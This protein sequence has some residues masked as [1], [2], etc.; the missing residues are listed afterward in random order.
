MKIGVAFL[1][2]II[3]TAIGTVLGNFFVIYLFHSSEISFGVMVSRFVLPAIAYVAVIS[4]L[5]GRNV[6]LF[7][8]DGFAAGNEKSFKLLKKIGAVPIKSI[9][10][11]VLVQ[12]A[13]LWIVIFILGKSLGV[14]NTVRIFLYC[15]CLA[16]GM[17]LGTLVYVI[18]DGLVMRKLLSHSITL[19]PNDLREDRQG[20]KACIIPIAVHLVS[21]VAA[22]SITVLMLDK[23]GVDVS[24]VEKGGWNIAILVLVAFCILFFIL[25]INLKKN[26]SSL[27]HSVISQLE[28]LSAGKK[29][30]RQR[31]HIASVDELGSIAG[32]MNIFCEN[33][34]ESMKEIK[35][36]QEILFASSTQLES[37]AQDMHTAV[38]RIA[39]AIVEAREKAEAGVKMLNVNQSSA[40]IHKIA[41]NIDALNG[42]VMTQSKSV[43]QASAAIEEMVGN[44]SSIGKV[45]GKMAEHFE[46]VNN[47]ADKGLSIQKNSTVSVDRI[48]AQSRALLD[49]NHIIADISS[50]TNLLAMNAAIEAAH[51][52]NAGR[53]FSVVADEIRKLAETASAESKKINEELNQ[54]SKTIDGI[55]KGT[56]SSATAFGAVSERV[57]ETENLIREVNNAIIEQQQ[58]VE[59]VLGALKRMNEITTEVKSGSGV[60]QENNNAMIGEI[61]LLQ[62]HSKDISSGMDDIT[63][64]MRNINSE[65]GEMS[66]LAADTHI[67]VEKIKNIVDSFEV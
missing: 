63:A 24:V 36:D 9:A 3:G 10:Q 33:I 6:R 27:Y 58:G 37:N 18:C 8:S 20:L 53:G 32:M 66:R 23:N 14:P 57:H 34:S 21:V 62:N 56:E 65:A 15:A 26:T 2:L 44:I 41:Q 5:L 52:G 67:T 19:Y 7:T 64:E 43:S 48:V 25:A 1:T 16:I 47:A 13:F 42:S 46:T 17:T 54:I 22:L 49:A 38:D 30:L 40:A 12:A 31:I 29:D 4:V 59:Q 60:M 45:T 55:V 35:A 28:N 11:I 39:A 51:A 61:S 50:K